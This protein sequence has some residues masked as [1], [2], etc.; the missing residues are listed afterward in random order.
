MNIIL[1]YRSKLKVQKLKVILFIMILINI[2][3]TINAQITLEDAIIRIGRYQ[4][5]VTNDMAVSSIQMPG[6]TLHPGEAFVEKSIAHLDNISIDYSMCQNFIDP[7][8]TLWKNVT[9]IGWQEGSRNIKF[10]L[11]LSDGKYMHNYVRYPQTEVTVNGVKTSSSESRGE[12]NPAAIDALGTNCDQ[13]IE[14]KLLT[15]VGLEFTRKIY[16]WSHFQDNNYV[17]VEMIV[18][19]VG[20]GWGPNQELKLNLDTFKFEIDT[21]KLPKQTIHNFL[22]GVPK[23]RAMRVI[24]SKTLNRRAWMVHYG[25]RDGDSLRM[26]YAYDGQIIGKPIDTVGEPFTGEDGRLQNYMGQYCALLYAPKSVDDRRD[27]IT[28]PHYTGYN[29]NWN[30]GL[31]KIWDKDD[32]EISEVKGLRMRNLVTDPNTGDGPYYEGADI[33]PGLHQVNM[34]ERDFWSPDEV[35]NYYPW[36]RSHAGP[37]EIPPGDSIKFVIAMGTAGLSPKVAFKVGRDW[38]KGIAKF[39]GSNSSPIQ[40]PSFIGDND[41]AKDLWTFTVIDSIRN[42]ASRSNWNYKK[43]NFNIPVPPPPLEWLKI[44]EVVGAIKLSWSKNAETTAGFEGYRIYRA[45]G[46]SDST[47]YSLVY[48]LSKRKGNLNNEFNDTQ[49]ERGPDYYYYVSTFSISDGPD[50]YK[51]GEILESGRNYVQAFSPSRF[52]PKEGL[53]DGNWQDSVRVVP[54]PFNLSAREVQF[55]RSPNKIMFVNLPKKCTIRIY[56]ENGNLVKTLEHSDGKSDEQ[57]EEGGQYMLTDSGQRVVSGI[58]IAHI[59]TPEGEGEYLKFAIVR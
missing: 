2:S 41:W 17:L 4:A 23:L 16:A 38:M 30:I 7:D 11:K 1:E 48:E 20:Y 39:D 46:A 35:P 42:S 13:Y 6:W 28:Q 25:F 26:L 52:V 5:I 49:V 59:Q 9:V 18:K 27:D 36:A 19:N 47:L 32:K 43:N 34:D 55:S 51:K 15:N 58:Y 37:Y 22:Y 40:R 29:Q 3:D 10:P 14:N 50:A 54:N 33:N 45:Q 44:E 31:P 57:W 21:V 56:S 53:A 24:G 8:S 12:L